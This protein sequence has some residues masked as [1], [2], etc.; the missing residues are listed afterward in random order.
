VWPTGREAADAIGRIQTEVSDAVFERAVVDLA[1]LG[2]IRG[3]AARFL[4]HHDT[5][6]LLVNNAGVMGPPVRRTTADGFE[7]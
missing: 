6:D 1:D 3:F 4:D 7:L 2:S 5:F